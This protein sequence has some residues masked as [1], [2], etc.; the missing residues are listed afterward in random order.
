M[1]VSESIPGTST[2]DKGK[3]R[4]TTY[5]YVIVTHSCHQGRATDEDGMMDVLH[6]NTQ[7]STGFKGYPGMADVRHNLRVSSWFMSVRLFLPLKHF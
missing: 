1:S 4:N 7:P 6:D 3:V 5:M 2:R